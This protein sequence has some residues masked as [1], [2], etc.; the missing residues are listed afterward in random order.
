[1]KFDNIVRY[2]QTSLPADF[3][4]P[5]SADVPL[6]LRDIENALSTLLAMTFWIGE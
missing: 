2:L 3:N 1:M 5:H 4:N 6:K